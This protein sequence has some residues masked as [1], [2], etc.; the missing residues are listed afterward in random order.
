MPQIYHAGK[1]IGDGISGH[2]V[3]D[4]SGTMLSPTKKIQFNGAI[5]ENS[6]DMTIVTISGG[7]NN[8]RDNL[9]L[10]TY[11]T[12]NVGITSSST[13][14]WNPYN[15]LYPCNQLNLK[16]YD[17]LTLS[18]HWTVINAPQGASIRAGL[19]ATSDTDDFF[20]EVVYFEGGETS[21]DVSVT[22]KINNYV[23]QSNSN[24][25]VLKI[26]NAS[27]MNITISKA[28]IEIGNEVTPWIPNIT[29]S[30]SQISDALAASY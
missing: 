23:L 5:V 10:N 25:F 27:G 9:L 11:E 21:G 30:A 28:K 18:F 20:G 3:Y 24:V 14:S 17:Y 29:D 22:V 12:Q 15:L 16:S 8:I 6:N 26:S 1:F 13:Y 2:N 19:G 4:S 7:G